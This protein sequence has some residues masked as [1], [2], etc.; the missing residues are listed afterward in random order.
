LFCYRYDHIYKGNYW[1]RKMSRVKIFGAAFAVILLALASRQTMAQGV[2]QIEPYPFDSMSPYPL[3]APQKFG[4]L[5]P[6]VAAGFQQASVRPPQVHAARSSQQVRRRP[7][8]ISAPRQIAARSLASPYEPQRAGGFGPVLSLAPRTGERLPARPFCFPSSTLHVQS[9]QADNC[10]VGA[11]VI[12]GRFE[13]L[14]A[15]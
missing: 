1:S 12:R 10:Y 4:T 14:L 13:E 15:E 2:L 11:P 8:P 7:S 3:G 6:A 9:N 5:P